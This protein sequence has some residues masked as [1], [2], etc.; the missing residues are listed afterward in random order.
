MARIVESKLKFLPITRPVATIQT[1]S[2]ELKEKYKKSKNSF[3]VLFRL[4]KKVRDIE[5][6]DM[7]DKRLETLDPN[8]D[9]HVLF[10]EYDKRFFNGLLSHHGVELSWSYRLRITSGMTY[11]EDM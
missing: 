4:P 7:G 6:K 8:P 5:S 1:Q 9:I 2:P 3:P 11:S 10:K